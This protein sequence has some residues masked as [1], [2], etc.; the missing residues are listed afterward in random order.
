MLTP[1]ADI[2]ARG[3]GVLTQASAYYHLL[4]SKEMSVKE[5]AQHL[6][7]SMPE[8]T[9]SARLLWPGAALLAACA[10]WRQ[11]HALALLV[12]PL[13]FA[14]SALLESQYRGAVMVV[15]GVVGIVAG[16]LVALPPLLSC[17]LLHQLFAMGCAILLVCGLLHSQHC[18]CTFA[19]FSRRHEVIVL[20]TSCSVMLGWM[21]E[22]PPR[23]MMHEH[24]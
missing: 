21:G 7:L 13:F 23:N 3:A 24:G 15:A 14:V 16:L 19:R 6:L 11:I 18:S 8:L 17:G 5:F 9:H 20:L 1:A 12:L 2:F 10:L 4:L 22:L